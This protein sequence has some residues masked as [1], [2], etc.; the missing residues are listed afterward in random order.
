MRF[1]RSVS[2]IHYR[3]FKNCLYFHTRSDYIFICRKTDTHHF[4]PLGCT[5]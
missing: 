2:L 4:H 3:S 1:V 5:E